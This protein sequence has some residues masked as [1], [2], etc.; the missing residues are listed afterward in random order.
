M[1]RPRHDV[2]E[3]RLAV[4]LEIGPQ[5]REVFAQPPREQLASP[6]AQFFVVGRAHMGQTLNRCQR[7]RRRS[8]PMAPSRTG[9]FGLEPTWPVA[10][11]ASS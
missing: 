11:C 7:S 5:L 4:G 1:F 10:S 2:A 3:K 9:T 8:W 6:G